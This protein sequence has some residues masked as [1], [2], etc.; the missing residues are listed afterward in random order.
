[1]HK[2]LLYFLL[3]TLL[4]YPSVTKAQDT[5]DVLAGMKFRNVGPTRGGRVT[6]VTGVPSRP[7][8]FYMGSTG[9]GVWKTQNYG[10]SW[11]N[12]SDGYF[13][14]ASMGAIRVSP[15]KPSIIYAGTGSDG[16]RSNVIVG[17]G[18]YKSSNS[19]K[20]WQFIGLEKVGQIGAI[21]IDPSSP[22]RV[23]VAAIGQPFAPN[24]ERGIYR[25]LNGGKTWKKVF[26][27][28]D[29]V[30]AADLEFAPDNSQTIYA[31]M[32]RAERK[33]WTIISGGK[34]S[35]GIYKSTDGGDTWKKLEKGLPT[36]L[37]GKI[38]LAVSV[39]DPNRLYALV[40]APQ[41]IGGLYR[42]DDQGESFTLISTKKELLDRPFYYC[43]VDVNP[44]N[45]D[46]VYVNATRAFK[47]YD[48]GKTWK[49]IITPHGDNHDI[50]INPKDTLLMVQ[51]NDG[52]ANVSRDGGQ[53]WSSQSNQSTAELYQVEVDDQ[54]PYWLYAGQQDNST[55]MVPSKPPYNSIA[56]YTAYW[57]AIG[58]CETGPAVPKPGNPNIVYS[59]CKGRF[60][61]YNKATG[62]E[63]QYYV[64]AS[65][66]YGHNPRDL[67]FRFQRVSPIH[68]S[69][70][71][72]DVVYHASQYL[73]K[74]T[75]DGKTWEIISPDLTANTPETQ[76]I[77]GSPITRDV[78]GEEFYSTIY[79]IRESPL[80]EGLI[81]VGANDGPIHVTQDGG[82]NWQKVTPNGLPPGGRVQCIEPSPHKA[83]KAY[84]AIYRYLL[85]DWQP[86][87]Y[88]TEDYG[89]TWQ[90]LTSG[91]NGIPAD[92]PTRVIREDPDQEGLL[93]AGT[94]F[95]LF[96]SMDDGITWLPFQQNLPV[97]PITDMKV[98]R[99]DLVISTMGR[100]FWILDD[101]T[102]LHQLKGSKTL[103]TNLFKPRDTYRMRYWGNSKDAIPHYP[104][105]GMMIYYSLA[106]DTKE[107]ILLDILD[108]SGKIIRS[109][110][111]EKPSKDSTDQKEPDM[112]TGFFPRG[113][114]INLSTK[115]GGHRVSW[116]LR[117]TGPWHEDKKRSGR[118]GPMAAPGEYTI[119]M[120]IGKQ[121]MKQKARLLAD[122]RVI[123]A[124][125][126]IE[127]IQAQA[128]LRK[129]VRDL[130]SETRRM[131]AGLKTRIK[132]L[133][134][135][136]EKAK[137]KKNINAEIEQLQKVKAKLSTA[138]GRYMQP[139]LIAQISYLYSMLGRADQK[140]GKDAFD[141]FE[142]LKK[143]LD[144]IQPEW[145]KVLGAN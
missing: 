121:V 9:G 126:K 127:D 82:K 23:F 56:G 18:V 123:K 106:E 5:L 112:A 11:K 19:G 28:A 54:F 38:D 90:K 136:L 40:E 118:N 104:Q 140:P 24:P 30:G 111:S 7:N 50:W 20:S 83:G 6:T 48:G 95:G 45:A 80:E 29:S 13:K 58:G 115:A 49:R 47:S 87:L 144:T 15:S 37:I 55:I 57:Q 1:M 93:Y 134:E 85:G 71:N 65:N 142:E 27:L 16:I 66:M 26:Y 52:G 94:E 105:P 91:T 25:T 96:V 88:K 84:A 143:W 132:E 21:E 133:E 101:L 110:T 120:T 4:Y 64:G 74:T 59:N 34:Q 128:T 22:D 92:Y 69:P 100:G 31:T 139:Q 67:K 99:Q 138:E 14:T 35:G 130:L 141:R 75:D 78:T 63:M 10:Q 135:K 125:L 122:P 81:W 32:W 70:H 109:Y 3:L 17:K 46:A 103:S 98:H 77:S 76:V 42:S 102:P 86:Y 131:E 129:S 113:T 39:A 43:N 97:T 107:H 117:L 124:G 12:I 119:R 114:D 68:V 61:V 33:P 51:A 72:P 73:H 44:L 116:D 137:N 145:D 79:A 53:T 8:E 60:G 41:G 108:Q 62:Q 2:T 89:K 36:D